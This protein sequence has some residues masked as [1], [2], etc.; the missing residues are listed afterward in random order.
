MLFSYLTIALRS[1]RRRPGYTAL[2]LIGLAVGMACCLL[3]GLYVQNE[4]SY[5]TF[6]PKH[7][8]IVRL[9]QQTEA[10]GIADIG[11]A[12]IPILQDQIPQVERVVRIMQRSLQTTIQDGDSERPFEEQAVIAVDSTFFEVFSGF[13]LRSGDPA[14]ALRR[15]GTAVVTPEAARR[16]FG[17]ADPMERTIR[18]PDQDQTLTVTGVLEPVPA[19]SHVQF[20]VVTNIRTL[21][22]NPIGSFWVP[23]A[24]TY[25]LLKPGTDRAAAEQQVRDAIAEERRPEVAAKYTP[26]LQPLTSLHL[27]STL[28]NEPPGQG[29][30]TQV[31]V[32]STIALFVLLIAAV[33]FVNL[34][35]ARSAERATEVGVRKSI[36]AQQG[37][38]VRQFLGEAVLLSIGGGVLAVFLTQM[39]LPVLTGILGKELAVGIW[40]NAWLW[41]G[42]GLVILVAGVGA[43]SYPA[44]VLSRFQPA[45]VLKNAGQRG[46]GR[47]G[48]LRKGL[49]VAQFAISVTLIVGTTVAYIQLDYLRTARLGF[50]QEQ[51]V[52]LDAEGDYETLK[53]ELQARQ[54]VER[55]T[56]ASV[57]PGLSRGGGYRYE[58]DG[59]RPEDSED[60]LN[61]QRVDFG[62]FETMGVDVI[63]GRAMS[64]ERRSDLGVAYPPDDTHYAPYYRDRAVVVNRATLNKFGWT[65][66]EAIGRSIRLYILENNTI[67]QDI[68]GEVVGVVEN[69]HTTSL[70]EPIPPVAYVPTLVPSPEGESAGHQGVR[71]VLARVQPGDAAGAMAVLRGVWTEVVPDEPF[72]ATFLDDR[73]QQQYEG[74]RK[75][76]QI[77]GIFSV[78]AILVACLGLFGLATYTARQR[79]KE[80]GIRKAVGASVSSIVGLLSKDFLKLVAVAVAVGTPAAYVAVDRWLSDFAYRVDLGPG[81]FLLAAAVAFAIAALTVSY[82][83]VRTAHTDPARALRSE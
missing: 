23:R 30:M 55:V 51:V 72:D 12:A 80:I 38:L 46:W 37:Q 25:A 20:G 15:P 48:M 61:I 24:W 14:T 49:V 28:S 82:H 29:S 75:L 16:Y 70:R 41:A 33:N 3:I 42:V 62:F 81:P 74:E 32:F 2:N 11:D 71:T 83:A 40:T 63:E 7:E 36:G 77:V 47:G 79:T 52:V 68:E 43:G 60:R 34:A 4:L 64:V 1:L 66:A 76:G 65:P 50:D 31:T 44:F 59:A 17:D 13:Q 6:H 78:L 67:Y 56:A 54:E 73:L 5:D 9:A 45:S 53:R 8:R 18:L 27:S 57:T 21:V 35:T 22:A 10:G 69:Y 19:N 58:V 26:I 39:T